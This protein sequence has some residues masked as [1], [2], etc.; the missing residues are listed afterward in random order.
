MSASSSPSHSRSSPVVD[1][2][3]EPETGYFE[4]PYSKLQIT[5]IENKNLRSDFLVEPEW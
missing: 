5:T 1:T 3:L 4:P 2:G